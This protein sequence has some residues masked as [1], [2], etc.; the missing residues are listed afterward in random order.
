VIYTG[1][2][3]TFAFTNGGRKRDFVIDERDGKANTTAFF[4]QVFTPDNS[5]ALAL[6]AVTALSITPATKSATV[7]TG[8]SYTLSITP[9][10]VKPIWVSSNPS[11]LT[12]DQE[13]NATPIKAGTAVVTATAGAYSSASVVTV[14]TGG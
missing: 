8:Y 4:S 7:G 2:L 1:T 13:G 3:T 12:V 5:S 6:S 9:P 10:G 14:S 11:V